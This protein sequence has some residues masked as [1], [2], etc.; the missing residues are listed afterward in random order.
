MSKVKYIIAIVLLLTGTIVI[1]R[2]VRQSKADSLKDAYTGVVTVQGMVAQPE[3]FIR[4]ITETGTLTGNRESVIAAETG[5]RVMEVLVD[6]G[7]AVRKG[8]PLVRLDDELYRLESERAKIAYDKATM[9]LER[10]ERL[11]AENSISQSEIE[12]VRLGAKSAEVGYRM[13]LK[14]YNDATIRA[15]FAGTVAS[16]L[17]EVGQMVERGMPVAQ[18]VDISSLK[19]NVQISENDVKY[20][21]PDAPATI[22][23]EALGDTMEGKVSSVGS[24]AIPGSRAFPVEL[25]LAGHD[26][27]RSGMFA[28]AVIATAP[29]DSAILLPRA[30]LLPDAGRTVA[31]LARG[32]SVAQKVTLRMIGSVGD[33]VAVD[34]L[35]VGDT[36]IT[37]GNQNLSTGSRLNLVMVQGVQP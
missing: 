17:T 32:G 36:V 18:L 1:S 31:F 25:R 5:G 27:L 9:D 28:R 4:H 34:G 33:R 16:R 24:R 8:D 15:P 3:T 30:A 7:D 10:L 13:A 20:L 6:V 11:F 37:T 23:I 29:T 21:T 22:I 12:N 35:A 26:R 2:M 19:L 14:T